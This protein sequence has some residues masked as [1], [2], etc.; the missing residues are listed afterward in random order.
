M[1]K[2]DD[3]QTNKIDFNTFSIKARNKNLSFFS[4]DLVYKKRVIDS[5]MVNITIG[6]IDGIQ[7]NHPSIVWTEQEHVVDFFPL[8]M[9]KPMTLSKCQF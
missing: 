2:A 4:I 6:G 5:T 3:E 7:T 8:V 9:N 1:I